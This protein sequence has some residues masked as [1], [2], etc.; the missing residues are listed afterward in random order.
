VLGDLYERYTSPRQYLLDAVCTVPLVVFSRIRRTTDLRVLLMEASVLY[1]SFL[2]A[3]RYMDSGFLSDPRGMFR[4]AIPPAA[5]LVALMLGDAYADPRKPSAV[6]PIRGTALALGFALFFQA[7]LSVG[8]RELALPFWILLSGGGASLLLVSA[9][10][11]LFPPV[12][13]GPQS[14]SGPAFWQ[15]PWSE[16]M[17]P[18]QMTLIFRTRLTYSEFLQEVD[19]GDLAGVTITTGDSG[20]SQADCR[21]KNGAIVRTV[22]PA[23]Y[24]DALAAMQ[25]KL[26]NIEIEEP[27]SR[28]LLI[29]ATPFLTLLAVWFLL[30]FG[31]KNPPRW[32]GPTGARQSEPRA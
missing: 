29:R 19:A 16:L 17:N 32:W 26:V 8:N 24:R 13:D 10:R 22:L 5:V 20:A 9:L 28:R 4:L 27:S 1:L 3:A 30:M 2:A 25:Q 23:D 6:K 11:L 7:L 18:R 21:L 14:A 12:A 15:E 31:M